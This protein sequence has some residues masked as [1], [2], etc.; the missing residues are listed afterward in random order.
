MTDRYGYSPLYS[1][2]DIVRARRWDTENDDRG[3][4]AIVGRIKE[5]LLRRL[6]VGIP[7]TMTALQREAVNRPEFWR[8]YSEEDL[9]PRHLIVQGATSAGKTLLSELCILDT[10]YHRKKAIVL[11]PLKA[12]VRERTEQFRSDVETGKRY[13]KV[14]GSSSDF[15]E[16]DERLINGDYHVAVIVYEKFFAMLSQ[17][18]GASKLMQDCDLL[19]VDE[20]SML[21]KEERGPK[22]EMAMEIVKGKY[23]NTRIVALGTCDCE[24]TRVAG[25]LSSETAEGAPVPAATVFS[26]KRPVALNEYVIE[27]DGSYRLRRIPSERDLPADG[28]SPA[29]EC[30][31]GEIDVPGYHRE[32]SPVERKRVLLRA[33]VRKIY[34][35]TPDARLLV[36]CGSRNECENLALY[37]KDAMPELFPR[38]DLGE[39]F[40][41]GLEACEHDENRKRLVSELLP[42]G[43]AYHHA[44]VSSNL[45]EL[46]EHEFQNRNSALR[47]IVATETL[48]IGVNMPFDVMI[49]TDVSVPKGVGDRQP[50][51]NQEY[52]NYIGRAGRLG[53]SNRP[54]ETY[55]FVAD[56]AEMMRY[57]SGY[58]ERKEIDSALKNAT[59]TELAPYFLSLLTN[60]IRAE[61]GEGTDAQLAALF[62]NSLFRAARRRPFDPMKL[63]TVLQE[64]GLAMIGG[65]RAAVLRLTEFGRHVA[66]YALSPDTCDCMNYYFLR[67]YENGAFPAGVTR[68]EIESDRYLL[69]ILYQICR[70]PEVERTS[71]LSY[72]EKKHSTVN[73]K[74]AVLTRVK[75][76]LETRKEDGT[77]RYHL[78]CGDLLAPDENRAA[79]DEIYQMLLNNPLDFEDLILQALMRAVILFY[80]TKGY[81]AAAIAEKTGFC[82]FLGHLP[83][84]DVER[85]AEI[86]S[87]HLDALHS[88]FPSAASLLSGPILA[89]DG[90]TD[91]WYALHTRVKYGMPRDLIQLAN[92]HVHGLDR[93]RLLRLG[94]AAKK[95]GVLPRQFLYTESDSTLRAFL[96]P[97]QLIT[98]RERLELRV[99][100]LAFD[101]LMEVVTKDSDLSLP[102]DQQN[103]LSAIHAW[104]GT[105]PNSLFRNLITVLKHPAFS[106]WEV[107][108]SAS[109]EYNEFCATWRLKDG[110][111]T[112]RLAV[113]PKNLSSDIASRVSDFLRDAERSETCILLVKNG[114]DPIP[115]AGTER[116][117]VLDT[118][119]LALSLAR[120]VS[121]NQ[122]GGS[123][124]AEF[125][126][127]AAGIY[128]KSEIRYFSL[129]RYFRTNNEGDPAPRFR[130]VCDSASSS[131]DE[132]ALDSASL[133]TVLSETED[134]AAFDVLPWG[135]A[136][137]HIPSFS[138]LPTVVL[139]N[140]AHVRRSRSLTSMLYRMQNEHFRNVLFLFDSDESVE[141]WRTGRGDGE[142]GSAYLQAWNGH[143]V[144]VEPRVA[145]TVQDAV[146]MI[147]PFVGTAKTEDFLVGISYAHYE[148]DVPREDIAAITRIA[149]ALANEFGQD[150]ILFDR[151]PK[152]AELFPVDGRSRSLGAYAKCR[153]FLNLWNRWTAENEN[154]RAEHEVIRRT[155]RETGASCLYLQP[156]RDHTDPPVPNGEFPISL[157]TDPAEIVRIARRELGKLGL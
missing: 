71:S 26:D 35:E 40:R 108:H 57:F 28:S 109:F 63:K 81:T 157:F 36:F 6:P 137:D 33:V 102:K 123:P 110:S 114:L 29:P 44:G 73:S 1:L 126:S 133:R 104:D 96:T 142:T 25:W 12:M 121:T 62:E 124:L 94:E 107:P 90:A 34:S 68:E 100:N 58:G 43:L 20:L 150:R 147:R 17:N 32:L 82:D 10:L 112:F 117:A 116:Y 80:W 11:V 83:S 103:A 98:L 131:P 46:V 86:V 65:R 74:I 13:Y 84:G 7:F 70:H 118:D 67:G 15:L 77:A 120:T 41:E 144:T 72:Q 3:I 95:A 155:G 56:D 122:D 92:K 101:T 87:F 127:D 50:L 60:G 88:A 5:R 93:N 42:H 152:A 48:T 135:A 111:R 154:C 61:Y 27:P 39:D 79:D 54:G 130:I 75:E 53:Q 128:T 59:E 76:I 55:L 64:N 52:R 8:D 143:L 138:D 31:E 91:A 49:V 51:T 156:Q 134:L 69:G 146:R 37:M 139:L 99:E 136:L 2:E 23:P 141:E 16:Y 85:L 4:P 18:S 19:V 47:A 153:F 22:L 38:R 113:L 148:G 30:A 89:E 151:F 14:Y 66:P 9:P 45:R 105:N 115:L 132:S 78:W 129:P 24:T 140:R 106:A 97:T 149:E 21:Q 125:L 145:P 119:F